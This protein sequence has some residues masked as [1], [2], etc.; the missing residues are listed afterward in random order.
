MSCGFTAV[1]DGTKLPIFGVIPRKNEFSDY[2]PPD[3]V[4]V[5]YKGSQDSTFDESVVIEYLK[6]IVLSYKLGRR[7][8][9]VLLIVDSARCHL[10]KNVKDYCEQ[11]SIIL[12]YIPPRFT[13]LLQPADVCWFSSIK[14]KY[15]EKWTDWFLFEEKTYNARSPGKF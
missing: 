7:L 3:N 9:K 12:Q 8:D 13:N 2:T 15:S 10:T 1:A 6:R 4:E 5:M 11:N 14:K